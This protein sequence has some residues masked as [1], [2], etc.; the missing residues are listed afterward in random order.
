MTDEHEQCTQQPPFL[1]AAAQSF[2]SFL[3]LLF[4][5]EQYLRH[6]PQFSYIFPYFSVDKL[7]LSIRRWR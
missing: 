5:L 6:Q 2:V 3:L 4:Y 7:E 1:Q